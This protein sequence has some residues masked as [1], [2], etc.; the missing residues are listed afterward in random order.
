MG[1]VGDLGL[2]E[3]RVLVSL[4]DINRRQRPSQKKKES[5]TESQ[6]YKVELVNYW[7]IK[8]NP[9]GCIKNIIF[10]IWLNRYSLQILY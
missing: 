10:E 2:G 1:V 5:R 6:L 9:S 3:N 7:R 8:K 4:T